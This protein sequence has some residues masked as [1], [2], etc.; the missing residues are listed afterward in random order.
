[1]LPADAGSLGGLFATALLCGLLLAMARERDGRPRVKALAS[2]VLMLTFL[3]ESAPHLVHLVHHALAADQGP[4]GQV[5][6][7]ADHADA[8]ATLATDLPP[9]PLVASRLAEVSRGP[10][11]VS[12]PPV[13]SGRAPPVG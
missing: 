8:T 5:L 3:A 9:V 2:G 11:T 12:T 13:A 1:M 6:V 10:G 4:H 7:S